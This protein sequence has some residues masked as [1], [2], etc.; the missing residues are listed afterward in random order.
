MVGATGESTSGDEYPPLEAGKYKIIEP[1][2]SYMVLGEYPPLGETQLISQAWID[3]ARARYD[4]YVAQ[5]GT[6]PPKNVQP[7]MGLDVAELGVD[8]NVAVSRYGGY[9]PHVTTWN[10]IDIDMTAMRAFD[11][12]HQENAYIMYVD[13]TGVGSGVAPSMARRGRELSQPTRAISVKVASKPTPGSQVE[14]GEFYSLRD[15]LWWAMREW[16]RTDSG[17]MLPPD[18]FLIADLRAPTYDVLR[19][20]IK[21]VAKNILRDKLKRSTDRADALA[22]T[23]MPEMKPKIVRLM[24]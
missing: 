23:F 17:A 15:Q 20:K 9:I 1:S 14:L 12:Y 6:D 7:I 8:A 21:V 24:E 13:A 3:N 4:A 22:L 18:P 10:G 2:F 16:L 19:G 5:N 11:V